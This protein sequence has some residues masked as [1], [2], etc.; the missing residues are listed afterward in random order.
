MSSISLAVDAGALWGKAWPILVAILFFGL[1]IIFHELGHFLFAKLFKVQV[2]EFSIGMG[3]A[4]IKF[5]KGETKYSLRLLPIGGYVSM[6]GEDTESESDR[7]FYKQKAWKR[8]I[9]IAAGGVVNLLMG[10]IVV[11][12][13][14]ATSGDLIGTPQVHSFEK[15]SLSAQNGLE[16]M[17]VI[18]K[19]N[20]K[21]VICFTDL[22]YMLSSDTDGEFDFV[23][24]R[25]GKKVT[26]DNVK[27][28]T[29]K[30][31]G[32]T[33]TVCDF[34]FVGVE[35]NFINVAKYSVLESAAT[36]KVVWMS[37]FDL[38]TGQY[39]FNDLSG[40]IGT[41]SYIADAAETAKTETDFGYL[42]NLMALI[43]IN[44]G[45]FN[46]LPVPAL[47]GGRLLFLLIEIVF[48]KPVPRKYEGWV[49]AAGL[50][51]LLLLMAVISFNDIL[52]LIRG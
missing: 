47:D 51:L 6:E 19:I 45:I 16:E 12:I 49:H 27:F 25:N 26:L 11:A 9:V 7:A 4:L 50:V 24:E 5:K 33:Y 35:P 31:D 23:V 40:P 41:V 32:I 3:P 22:K 10:V 1:I 14:L 34:V 15:D 44:I 18:K 43:T 46:L 8:F 2:N 48:R 39:G 17:D 21:N 37:L 13:M 28:E 42:L 30:A 29:R 52:K 36:A 38:V 20:G